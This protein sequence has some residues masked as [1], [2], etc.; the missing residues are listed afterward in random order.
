MS[1][2]SSASCE[3]QPGANRLDVAEPPVVATCFHAGEPAAERIEQQNA[4][5]PEEVYDE[6]SKTGAGRWRRGQWPRAEEIVRRLAGNHT[7]DESQSVRR[8]PLQ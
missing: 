4:E 6:K 2:A 3:K 1:R 8:Y 5:D 7:R